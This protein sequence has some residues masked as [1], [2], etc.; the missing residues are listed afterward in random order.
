MFLMP[1]K[2]FLDRRA[3]R[4]AIHS[5]YGRYHQ[6][7]YDVEEN[8]SEPDIEDWMFKHCSGRL[9]GLLCVLSFLQNCR[10]DWFFALSRLILLS[11]G[12]GF[13]AISWYVVF[14]QYRLCT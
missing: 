2:R 6:T 12:L 9:L 3:K 1:D 10:P 7:Q 14:L 11:R 8:Q 4:L 13:G 5:L